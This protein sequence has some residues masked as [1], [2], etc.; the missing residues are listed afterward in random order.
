MKRPQD[1]LIAIAYSACLSLTAPAVAK[2]CI[3]VVSAGGGYAF[4]RAVQAGA[5]QAGKELGTE[6]YFRGPADEADINAQA[7][8][9]D[10]IVKKQ[11]KALVLAPNAPQRAQQV[12]LLRSQ[13]IP[14]VYID[15]DPGGAVVAGVVATN[16]FKAGRLAGQ[17]M[18]KAL[19]AKGRVAVLRLKK[20]VIST[21]DRERG[22]IE[23]ARQAGL[24]IVLDQYLGTG[25]GEARGHAFQI[26]AGLGNKIDGIFTPNESTTVAT[27]KV[28]Q[29]RQMAGKVV[30]IGFDSNDNLIDALKGGA[31]FGL[32]VQRPFEMGYQG[33]RIAQRQ[34]LGEKIESRN[35]DT[36]VAFA[37][38]ANMQQPAIAKLLHMDYGTASGP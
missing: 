7:Y 27:L 36:G 21:S 22:F 17:E 4:W 26:L 2:D 28:L 24:T 20:G 32:V 16:N 25:V 33:V 15:R 9:I 14:T 13:G 8:I 19:G 5:E 12:A 31:I 37:T 29:E 38:R 30:H 18:G 34:R 10:A 1:W 23:G 11:C 3:G 6:I 35:I